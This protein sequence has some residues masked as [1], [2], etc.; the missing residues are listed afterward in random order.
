MGVLSTSRCACGRGL[1]VLGDL[2]G[3]STDFVVARDGTVL[4]GLALIY[5]LRDLPEVA[6]FQIRQVSLDLTVVRVVS[7]TELAPASYARIVRDFKARLG[8]AVEIRVEQVAT[9]AP[10]PSGKF[11]Y[12]LSQ[13]DAFTPYKECAQHA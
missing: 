5:T 2:Q 10:E 13:V 6:Q 7:Q 3:R 11:R 9:I 8:A 12:V 1:P 4:H